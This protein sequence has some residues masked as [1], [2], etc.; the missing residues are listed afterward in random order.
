MFSRIS[1]SFYRT[2]AWRLAFRSTMV[3]AGSSAV[4]F[5]VMYGVVARAFR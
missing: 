2:A 1:G 5:L 3:F 4:V